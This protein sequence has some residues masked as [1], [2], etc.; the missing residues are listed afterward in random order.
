MVGTIEQSMKKYDLMHQI[1][2]RGTFMV[3]KYCLPHLLKSSN[4]HI[5]NLSPPLN[6]KAHWFN[7]HL[8]YTMAKYGMSMCVLGMAE[9]FK[10]QVAVNALW[11]RTAIATAAVKNILGGDES[12]KKSRNTDIMADS[13]YVILTSNKSNSANFYIVLKLLFR[14]KKFYA[15]M[16]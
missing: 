14:M 15:R 11:P 4:P 13:A 5:L 3:S 1:N 10:G 8:A 2:I 16:E 6:M 12:M 9:E 7:N